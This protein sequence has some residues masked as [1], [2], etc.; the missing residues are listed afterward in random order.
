MEYR[1]YPVPENLRR[2]VKCAWRLCD[3]APAAS[4]QTIYPDGHCELI[5]H[6]AT[7]PQCW[8]P[9]VG[10]R[11]QSSSLFAAQRVTAVRLRATAPLD[12]IGLRLRPAASSLFGPAALAEQRDR[13]ADLALIHA[14]FQQ[15][16]ARRG[17]R[18]RFRSR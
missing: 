5:V 3:A 1:E 15:E 17:A 7:P 2:H 16:S 6:L 18:V 9:A 8:H 4:A 13:I 10:W 12:C 14:A 11:H